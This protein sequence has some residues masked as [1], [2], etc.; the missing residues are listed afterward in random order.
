MRPVN[1]YKGL[2][3]CI[4]VFL[5]PWDFQMQYLVWP[6]GKKSLR[7]HIGSLVSSSSNTF[8]SPGRFV[9]FCLFWFSYALRG[10][11]RSRWVPL[12][13]GGSVGTWLCCETSSSGYEWRLVTSHQPLNPQ[14]LKHRSVKSQTGSNYVVHVVGFHCKL[15]LPGFCC[16][17]L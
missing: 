17:Q 6:L 11:R 15:V 9:L 14:N 10:R 8:I 16:C 2:Y 12:L 4:A 5:S 3:F 7:L 13:E 1:C